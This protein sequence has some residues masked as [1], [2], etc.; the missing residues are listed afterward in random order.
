M[1]KL[2]GMTRFAPRPPL[3]PASIAAPLAWTA[4]APDADRTLAAA[5][6]RLA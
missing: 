5:K 6:A 4:A 3:S 2:T 1:G